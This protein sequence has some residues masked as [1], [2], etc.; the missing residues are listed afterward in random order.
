MT[1]RKDNLPESMGRTEMVEEIYRILG[2]ADYTT[3]YMVYVF[4]KTYISE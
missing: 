4:L 1:Q 2:D 3:V